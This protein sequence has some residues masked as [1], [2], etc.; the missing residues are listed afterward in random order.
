M[1]TKT[2]TGNKGYKM[3][4]SIKNALIW[5]L[6]VFLFVSIVGFAGLTANGG[7]K[8]FASSSISDGTFEMLD[9]TS[10][11]LGQKNGLRFIVKMDE[12]M[13]NFVKGNDD[14]EMGF[15]IA[16]KTIVTQANGD[17]LNMNHVGGAIDKNKI[18]SEDGNY[19]ANGCIVNIQ[20]KNFEREFVAVAYVKQGETVRY[21]D[22]ND[23]ARGDLYEVVNYWWLNGY[24]QDI[25]DSVTA[26]GESVYLQTEENGGWYGSEQFPIVVETSEQ[27][28][29]LVE[30]AGGE[31]AI[32]VT[33]CTVVVKDGVNTSGSFTETNKPVAIINESVYAVNELISALPD[34]VTMPD[35]ITHVARI[36]DAE[37]AYN[38]LSAELKTQVDEDGV[39]KLESLVNSIEGYDRVY[40]HDDTD[41][42][43][44]ASKV[45]NYS[46]EIGG[47]G[48]TRQD[49]QHGNVLTVTSDADGKAALLIE[50]LPDLSNYSAI[51]FY[52]RAIG[53]SCNLYL[54]DG[55]ENDGW[56]KNWKN[57][58]SG[59][60][61]LWLN[62]GNWGLMSFDLSSSFTTVGE[63]PATIA[64]KDIFAG[65]SLMIGLRTD[66]A[67]I[68]F[69]I[70][71]IFGVSVYKEE[72]AGTSF[73][74]ISDTGT[75]NEY[76][77]V[78]NFTQSWS[79][80]KD[81]G[82]FSIG[83]MRSALKEE[84]NALCFYIYNPNSSDLQFYVMEDVTW[85]TTDVTT[86][87]AQSW[88]KVVLSAEII[89][90]NDNYLT[91]ICVESGANASGWQ[92][93]PIYSFKMDEVRQ[94]VTLDFG[95][96]TDTGT[97]N[98]YGTIY[99][100]SR[101][102]WFIDNDNYNTLGTLQTNEL[103]SALPTG[104]EFF[105]FWMYNPTD[106]AYNFHL[107]GD[108]SGT[109]TDTPTSTKSLTPKTWT[110]V[111]M[112][113]EDIEL[114]KSG[115]WYVYITGGDGQGAAKEGWQIS[116]IYAGPDKTVETE[117][118]YLD[119]ADV[120]EVIKLINA[121]PDTVSES[122]EQAVANAENAYNALKDSQKAQVTN[123]SKLTSAR[124]RLTDLPIANKVTNLINALNVNAVDEDLTTQARTA[125]DAL[126]DSQKALVTNYT[127][128]QECEAI[129][130]ASSA[131]QARI[132]A[133]ISKIAVLP[134]SVVMPDHLVMVTRI[135]NANSAYNALADD[136]KQEVTNY[137]KLRTLVNAIKGYETIHVQSNFTSEIG[138]TASMGYDGYYGDYI[139]VTPDAGGKAALQYLNFPD[140]SA[141]EKLYFNIKV[142]GASCDIYLS[143][144][145][146]VDGWG[147]GYNNTWSLSGLWANNGNWIQKE[148]DLSAT[149][150]SGTDTK[151]VKNIFASNLTIGLRT[152][153]TD[154]SFA[155]TN[156]IGLKPELGDVTNAS[157]G[158]IADSGTTNLY[159]TVYNLTQ[160]GSSDSDLGAFNVGIMRSALSEGHDSLRF[161]I[162]NPNSSDLQFYVMENET[163][164]KTEVITL[165]ANKWTEVVL[166]S[167][168]ISSN[169]KYLTYICVE[170]GASTDGWQISPI[171]SFS[172]SDVVDKVQARIDALNTESPDE[173]QVG[174]ARAEFE[175]LTEQQ[176]ALVN[177]TNL[178]SC[179]EALYGAT[180][181]FNFIVDGATQYKIYYAED[182]TLAVQFLI[183]QVENA[184]GVTLEAFM[185]EPQNLSKY[186][187]AIVV[188]WKGKYAD[189]LQTEYVENGRAG[190][191][192]KSNGR[193]VFIQA[194]TADGYRLAVIKFLNE[195]L[196]YDML[197]DDC[198]VYSKDGSTIN[199]RFDI[200]GKPF[201]YR[202]QQT[203]MTDSEVY[204]MGLQ[205]H[206]D[207]WVPSPDGWDM[208]NTTRYLPTATYQSAHSSWYFTFTDSYGVSRTDIC[209]TAGGNTTEFNAMV[210]ALASGMLAQISSDAEKSENICLSIMDSGDPESANPCPCARCQ[211][212]ASVYG[213]AGFSAAWIELMNAVN[214]KVRESLPE[215]KV[216]NIAFLAYRLTINAPV[217]DDLSLMKRYDFSS[218][219]ATATN[220]DLKCDE[221]VTAWV[222]PISALYAENFNFADN[223][224]ELLNIKKWLKVSDS[225]YIW[226]YG[227]NFKYYMYPY[228]TWKSSAEN[229]KILYDLGVKAVWSQSNETEATA[230]SDLKGY[231]DSK[232]MIDVNADYEAVLD[233]YFANYFGVAGEKMR[234]MFDAIVENCETI[235]TNNSG[236][237]RGIYDELEYESGLLWNKTTKSYWSESV[238]NSLVTLCDEAIALVEADAT[239]TDA[240]KTA[241][242]DRITKES[243]FPRYVLKNVYSATDDTFDNDCTRL[244]V[245]KTSET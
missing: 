234:A 153:S 135:E 16:P 69:E 59:L 222:A 27:Y 143:D 111:G 47:V 157:F 122:D 171:Y 193:T 240:Q 194:H 65:D 42:N 94:E 87:T 181:E 199:G 205:S 112:S 12:T 77:P 119:N 34:S 2:K 142:I 104:Y 52:V 71:D 215:G 132:E 93:S 128:L 74:T 56:G 28:A 147:D 31:N 120:K 217:N 211:L 90:S 184:T 155:I 186:R 232:F 226:L 1:I 41:G 118:V 162:Y 75:T 100:V 239:L 73:G 113:A 18:Y 177:K 96:R 210:E 108:V 173:Y 207:I 213:D 9:G 67:G 97:T 196:G 129:L 80:E 46:S 166:S 180:T 228:N 172:V 39:S 208:H 5:I 164:V 55:T 83:A 30:L 11:K 174:L 192:V 37:K 188:G 79:S 209:P 123:Y 64:I 245:T 36:R 117:L 168:I 4:K 176:K 48:V 49:S 84:H 91:Y 53:D 151:Y 149:Y 198:V 201:D 202:Q 20:L 195:V 14:V 86:V 243:L 44:I 160:G 92:I 98:E 107:A 78:Y 57:T 139:T 238:L 82:A 60:D 187:N 124:Q 95:I 51:Y 105:Y 152:E 43:V 219:S 170:S 126:T 72:V 212:Y 24:A 88:T 237:G 116:P 7:I 182:A 66:V 109:W 45:P 35:A 103:A 33:Q 216:V 200:V 140:V 161:F 70:S 89:S 110:K 148:F 125:Y 156:I 242:I 81:L 102:Q 32:N 54:S 169:D 29:N 189:C 68:T 76:G 145:F 63:N 99:N 101:E 22:Y 185:I 130:Q 235:E 146:G 25:A 197:S 58:W 138:G 206:A 62:D 230:F 40:K 204:G 137:A 233:S 244:G 227:T 121:L 10:L 127:K 8:V 175:A 114:N 17:Y 190:Y 134:D 159:G 218:G 154:V 133:V 131:R 224:D 150:V 158:N 141:Y 3:K 61:G 225:V 167:E 50:D 163:W 106:T 26:G 229:Y 144:G 191:A 23:L 136:E 15:I 231:I 203:Y 13:Y 6:S 178:T 220:E 19:Y 179:E 223:Q 165:T 38:A 183:A 115:Q 241:I 236:L 21:T 85:L 214:A 221:G